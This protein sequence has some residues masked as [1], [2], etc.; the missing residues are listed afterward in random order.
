LL[1]Y[2]GSQGS[3]AINLVIAEWVQRGLPENLYMIWATGRATYAEFKN[4]DGGSYTIDLTP[5]A[6]SPYAAVRTG[7]GAPHVTDVQA[8]FSLRRK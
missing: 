8:T 6:G 5:A 4:L 2:G 7:I 3:R 1:V